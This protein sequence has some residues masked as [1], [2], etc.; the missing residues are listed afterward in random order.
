[1]A[2]HEHGSMDISDHEKTFA[3]FV[4]FTTYAVIGILIFL[5]LLAMVNG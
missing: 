4:K 3:G 2:E 1:M 5:V